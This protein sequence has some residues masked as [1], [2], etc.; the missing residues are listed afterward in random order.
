MARDTDYDTP[1]VDL[2]V[3]GKYSIKESNFLNFI[4]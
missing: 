4:C 3:D 2:R 1:D